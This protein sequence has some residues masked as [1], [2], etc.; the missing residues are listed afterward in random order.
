[1][2]A[3]GYRFVA[4]VRERRGNGESSDTHAP[5]SEHEGSRWGLSARYWFVLGAAVLGVATFTYLTWP[6]RATDAKRSLPS[7]SPAAYDSVLRARYLSVR[8]TDV[9]TQAAIALLE[10]A[11]ALDPGYAVAYADLAAA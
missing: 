11:V 7:V 8:T 2:P 4:E 9:D 6:A 5:T 3:R 1:V 10:R